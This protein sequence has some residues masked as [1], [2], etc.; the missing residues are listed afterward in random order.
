M[1]AREVITKRSK[2]HGVVRV[3]TDHAV[4]MTKI[5]TYDYV[6]SWSLLSGYCSSQVEEDTKTRVSFFFSSSSA[7]YP[8]EFTIPVFLQGR[9]QATSQLEF[10]TFHVRVY[11]L[12]MLKY[13]VRKWAPAFHIPPS[14]QRHKLWKGQNTFALST[15]L[16]ERA[17]PNSWFTSIKPQLHVV[18]RKMFHE[19]S[20]PIQGDPILSQH[21][22][23][24]APAITASIKYAFWQT[25]WNTIIGNLIIYCSPI[26]LQTVPANC[27]KY[28]AQEK[29]AY[30][31]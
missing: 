13:C 15:K 24:T 29:A 6:Q 12:E 21:S 17:T 28:K 22:Q 30:T 11:T 27:V 20:E 18:T 2:H 23:Q 1:G 8:H 25:R 9:E 31:F 4:F 5:Y 3:S 26:N 16:L 7:H 14:F 19:Q 10:V